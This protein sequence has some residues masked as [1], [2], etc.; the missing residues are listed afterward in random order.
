MPSA[1]NPKPIK[2]RQA[3]ELSPTFDLENAMVAEGKQFIAGV[4]EV[5]CGPWAGPLVA[6]AAVVDPKKVGFEVLSMIN[7]SKKLTQKKREFLYENITQ[8]PGVTFAV[9]IA[10]VADIDSI[11]I[12]NANRLAMLK[13]VNDLSL[14]LPVD[15]LLIDGI[16]NPNIN[17]PTKM[18]IRGDQKSV[19]IAI[20]SVVAKVSRDKIMA[21]LHA[22]HPEYCWDSN[23]GY[24]T[25]KHIDA[26]KRYGIT[27]HH[28]KSFA[29]IAALINA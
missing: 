4:D 27:Q 22:Q 15:C 8:N 26:L 2:V 7:D 11:G 3:K 29:P 25:K 17:I 18:V 24:G 16:R 13:A 19:S 9:G 6:C 12:G 10:D 21:D 28:R 20:A 14:C 23:A 5:G 1:V